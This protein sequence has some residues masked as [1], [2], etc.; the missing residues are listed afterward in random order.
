MEVAFLAGV[1]SIH[2]QQQWNSVPFE[3]GDKG[4]NWGPKK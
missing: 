2:D 1:F 4:E 3:E